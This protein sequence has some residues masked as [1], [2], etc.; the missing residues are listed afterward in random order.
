[1]FISC[2]WLKELTET[3]L[4]PPELRERPLV[5]GGDDSIP[6]MVVG[7]YR[8]FKRIHLLHIDA[9]IDFRDEVRGVRDGYSS[10]IRRIREMPWI[11]RIVQVGMRGPGSARPQDVADARDIRCRG[12]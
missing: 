6:P 2:E 7:A 9:H 8:D 11:D 4:S 3:M 12:G 1:M 10:P 5:V